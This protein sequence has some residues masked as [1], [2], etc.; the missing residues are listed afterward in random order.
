MLL[1]STYLVYLVLSLS[2]TVWVGRT[3]FRNGRPFLVDAFRGNE[4]LAD[5]VNHLLVVGFYLVNLGYVTLMLRDRVDGTWANSVEVLSTKI[6]WVALVLG[7]VHFMNLF[8]LSKFRR[9][10]IGDRFTSTSTELR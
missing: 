10:A 3:L 6:G 2:M 9:S 4:L 8:L 1:V 7:L 5:S